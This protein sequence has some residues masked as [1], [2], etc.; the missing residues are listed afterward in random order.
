MSYADQQKEQQRKAQEAQKQ[1]L[2]QAEGAER[3]RKK[4]IEEAHERNICSLKTI[5][6]RSREYK[7]A[8]GFKDDD[9]PDVHL[10]IVI[11]LKNQVL[12]EVCFTNIGQRGD[13]MFGG[14]YA[15][16]YSSGSY[17]L[18]GT[19]FMDK[20]K[21]VYFGKVY[22][23]R[24][25]LDTSSQTKTGTICAKHSGIICTAHGKSRYNYL[26]DYDWSRY[27][28]SSPYA[29]PFTRSRLSDCKLFDHPSEWN[30][31]GQDVDGAMVHMVSDQ[32][33]K[34]LIKQILKQW[35]H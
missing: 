15:S 5:K 6:M 21:C 26:E 29:N 17:D 3:L 2:K 11:E 16:P 18:D 10:Y 35:P 24:F 19:I 27:D 20:D 12:P 23:L 14:Y 22:G 8:L 28:W 31:L 32:E 30:Q 13:R 1:A 34:A 25:A 4:K 9:S 33:H 7:N